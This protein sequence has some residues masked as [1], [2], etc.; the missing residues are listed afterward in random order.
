MRWIYSLSVRA[1]PN[2]VLA[3]ALGVM[4][5]IVGTLA[6]LSSTRSAVVLDKG[7]PAGAIQ[8]YLKTLLS[9]QNAQ[10]AKM[11]SPESKC[12]VG[13]ID[14]AYVLHT[15]RV[16]LIDSHIQGTTSEVRVRVEIPSG[17]PFGD[18]ASEDHSFQLAKINGSWLITGIPWPLFDCG[19]L[20]K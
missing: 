5:L 4:I 10:T 7:T 2:R 3:I 18:F 1:N 19:V 6:V 9:G 13:D 12:T 14:R 20:S 17:G 8:V 15:T 16:I 11:F